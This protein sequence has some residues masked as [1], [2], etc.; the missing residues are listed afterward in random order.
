MNQ[1]PRLARDAWFQTG[2]TAAAVSNRMP[3]LKTKKSIIGRM[4]LTTSGK[5]LR[6]KA[7]RGHMRVT[8]SPKQ[9]RNLRKQVRVEGAIGKS[10]RTLLGG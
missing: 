3:K 6:T 10:Y 5:V 4:K 9:R 2:R 7:A 8:K 1:T